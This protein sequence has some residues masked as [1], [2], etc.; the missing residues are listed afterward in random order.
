MRER[1]RQD[2][3]GRG[4][5]CAAAVLGRGE[6]HNSTSKNGYERRVESFLVPE[7]GWPALIRELQRLTAKVR[8][9]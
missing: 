5:G 3:Y 7:N 6:S 1:V 9:R 4:E 2:G 8:P